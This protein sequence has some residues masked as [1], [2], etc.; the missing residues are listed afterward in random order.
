MVRSRDLLEKVGLQDL[1]LVLRE[2]RLRWYGH[3]ERY[4]GAI[5]STRDLSLE[6]RR[7]PGRLKMSW[8]ELTERD[9]KQWKLL[10][11]NPQDRKAWRSGILLA[12]KS[13][14]SKSS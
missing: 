3:V 12:M 4:N 7:G 11:S 2:H 14:A 5:K 1:D 6:G 8:Q 9:P 10:S 13:A